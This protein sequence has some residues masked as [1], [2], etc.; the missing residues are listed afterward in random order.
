[1]S[2]SVKSVNRL[3]L[4]N[5][6]FVTLQNT[7]VI[8]TLSR[9]CDLIHIFSHVTL[10]SEDVW[11]KHWDKYFIAYEDLLCYRV[12][13]IS[14]NVIIRPSF[15]VFSLPFLLAKFRVFQHSG[16]IYT[17]IPYFVLAASCIFGRNH[18][19]LLLFLKRHLQS[20]AD[21]WPTLMGFSIYI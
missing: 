6:C 14:G 5:Y 3:N 8:I 9:S 15:G 17:E 16:N 12:I 10:T 7:L 18:V 19:L 2:S 13:S 11:Q 4:H 21:L 1:M 20:F